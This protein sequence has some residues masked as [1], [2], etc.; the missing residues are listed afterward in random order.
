VLGMTDEEYAE[1]L[2]RAYDEGKLLS[3]RLS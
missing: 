1:E 2:A 3:V